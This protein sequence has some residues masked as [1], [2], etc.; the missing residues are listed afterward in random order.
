MILKYEFEIVDMG[1][2]MIAVPIGDRSKNISGVIRLN[3]EGAE[4]MKMLNVDISEEDIV[5]A[6]AKKY[7]N[8]YEQLKS[9]VHHFVETL[10]DMGV[11]TN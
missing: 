11:L 9:Y 2:E 3:N 8:N 7:E 4:V 5:D 10:I 1:D 6:L